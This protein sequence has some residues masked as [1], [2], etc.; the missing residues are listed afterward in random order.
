MA[1]TV[2]GRRA[3]AAGVLTPSVASV[4]TA[5][6]AAASRMLFSTDRRGEVM[7]VGSSREVSSLSIPFER[8]TI[9]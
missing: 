8:S 7:P 1:L 6:H 3:G 5:R 9:E 2:R 4:D